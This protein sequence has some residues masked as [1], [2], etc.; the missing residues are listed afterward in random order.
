MITAIVVAFVTYWLTSLLGYAVHWAIHK[1][2]SGPFNKSHM[3]HHVRLYPPGDLESPEYRSAGSE[4]STFTFI[5]AF[6]PVMSIP[7]LLWYLNV[8]SIVHAIA[9]IIIMII[10]GVVSDVIHASFHVTDHW[11]SRMIPCHARMKELH[12]VH[13]RNMRKNFGIYSF[14]WDRLF[15]TLKQ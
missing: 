7:V 12:F 3:A 9:A 11:L 8:I 6:L 5:I 2:W 1:R 13:H 4:A 15:K 14:L 10:V